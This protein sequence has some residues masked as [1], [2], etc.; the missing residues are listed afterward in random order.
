MTYR[1]V[2][3]LV[4]PGGCG[5]PVHHLLPMVWRVPKLTGANVHL[6]LG[7]QFGVAPLCYGGFVVVVNLSFCCSTYDKNV[8]AQFLIFLSLI[9]S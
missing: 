4:A 2:N 3:L 8:R 5:R 9:L 1:A 6:G 7:G